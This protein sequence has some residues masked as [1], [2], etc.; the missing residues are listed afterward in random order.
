MFFMDIDAKT[1][2]MLSIGSLTGGSHGPHVN[3]LTAGCRMLKEMISVSTIFLMV[4][5]AVF[6]TL[7]VIILLVNKF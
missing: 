4:G 7:F 1:Y 5:R 2:G 6:K 3:D